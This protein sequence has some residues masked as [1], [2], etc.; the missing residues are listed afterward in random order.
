[1]HCILCY[2]ILCVHLIQPQCAQMFDQTLF[3][4]CLWRCLWMTLTFEWGDWAGC[5]PYCGQPYPAEG[6]KADSSKSRRKFLTAELRHE[7]FPDSTENSALLESSTFWLSDLNSH[8]RFSWFSG[9][10]ALARTTHW[11]SYIS[12]FLTTGLRSSQ[13]L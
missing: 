13:P 1:M 11:L 2:L 9:L 10:C 8:L 7:S 6:Q 5:P 3:W 4:L 12:N